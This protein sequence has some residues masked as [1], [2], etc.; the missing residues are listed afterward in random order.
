MEE[1]VVFVIDDDESICRSLR[2]LMTSVGF[3]V[4]TFTSGK[5][6]LN[7]GC[8]TMSGCIV[9]DVKMPEISGLDVQKRLNDSG[10]KIPIIF[11]SAHQ[12]SAARE[13]AVSAGA[14]AFL[15]KPFDGQVLIKTIN[16][17]LNRKQ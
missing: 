10:V 9:L 1:P 5:D 12:E 11:M 2:R 17:A 13:Q 4:R 15:Q 8:Q 6:F 7:Q 16:L 3:R 14:I